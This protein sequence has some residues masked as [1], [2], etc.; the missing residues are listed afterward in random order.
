M[1]G[2][3]AIASWKA[4][5]LYI[6]IYTEGEG[7]RV[8]WIG[9]GVCCRDG[10][11]EVAFYLYIVRALRFHKCMQYASRSWICILISV[12]PVHILHLLVMMPF[13]STSTIDPHFRFSFI[14]THVASFNFIYTL[15]MDIQMMSLRRM[16]KDIL[17]LISDLI[18]INA[19]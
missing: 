1:D 5:E 14:N 4:I 3:V 11:M 2:I 9:K 13:A 12:Q 18:S 16:H 6:Y 7:D 17:V 15:I 8:K 10:W 19:L